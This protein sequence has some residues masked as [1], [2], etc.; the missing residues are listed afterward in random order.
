VVDRRASLELSL[1]AARLDIEL[2]SK[3]VDLAEIHAWCDALLESTDGLPFAIYDLAAEPKVEVAHG[4]LMSI[5]E[6]H[7]LRRIYERAWISF[8]RDLAASLEASKLDA[9]D[10]IWRL[11]RIEDW[12]MPL[13]KEVAAF[14]SSSADD[15]NLWQLWNLEASPEELKEALVRWLAQWADSPR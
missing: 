1:R 5:A 3:F 14:K 13:P 12:C 6:E 15:P 8:A 9:T 4:H 7:G 11:D 10:A 2:I